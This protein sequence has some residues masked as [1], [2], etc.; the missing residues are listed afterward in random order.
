MVGS[1]KQRNCAMSSAQPFLICADD[2]GLAPGVD[3]AIIELIERRVVGA[4]SVMPGLPRWPHDAAALFAARARHPAQVGWH[5]TLTDQPAAFPHG[6]LADRDGCLPPLTR[7]LAQAFARALPVAAL[8]DELTAQLE[9]FA[10][11]W[12]RLPDFVDGHQHV[13]L[14]PQ[15]RDLLLELLVTR[16]PAGGYWVRD[17]VEPLVRLR[18]RGVAVGKAAFL[19]RLGQ[20]WRQRIERAG[21]AR[22]DGFAG[23]HDFGATPPFREKFRRFLVAPGPRHLVF[24]HPGIPDAALARRE[25]LVLPRQWEFD[26]LASE[27]LWEDLA[28]A[29]LWPATGWGDRAMEAA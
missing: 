15:V 5:V 1:I 2:F 25:R 22:N 3:A 24:V 23:A 10:E 21:I 18:R 7:L 20:G 29:G 17:T 12:G 16:F 6:R 8:R 26:Y 11:G 28:A 19:A 4:T 9:A 27:A 14:L 13:H